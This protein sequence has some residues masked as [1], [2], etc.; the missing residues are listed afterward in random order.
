MPSRP[1]P[2]RSARGR[3]A[4]SG[5]PLASSATITQTF[6]LV[7]MRSSTF[8]SIERA[9]SIGSVA[10]RAGAGGVRDRLDQWTREGGGSL[11]TNTPGLRGA[12][13]SVGAAGQ[14]VPVLPLEALG[15]I[16][17]YRPSRVIGWGIAGTRVC[18]LRLDLEERVTPRI[19]HNTTAIQHAHI[20]FPPFF[21]VLGKTSC[22][23]WRSRYGRA[24]ASRTVSSSS[25]SSASA[26]PSVRSSRSGRSGADASA[27]TRWRRAARVARPT[28]AE[29]R[30]LSRTSQASPSISKARLGSSIG[31]SGSRGPGSAPWRAEGGPGGRRPRSD[32][33]PG[34][35]PG[36]GGRTGCGRTGRGRTEGGGSGGRWGAGGGSAG[37]SGRDGPPAPPPEAC[38]AMGSRCGEPLLSATS[39]CGGGDARCSP[40]GRSNPLRSGAPPR[41]AA[42]GPSDR[43]PQTSWKASFSPS[44]GGPRS[45]GA[46]A[47]N[48]SQTVGAIIIPEVV[49]AEAVEQLQTR[50]ARDGL[51]HACELLE[52]SSLREAAVQGVLQYS[53]SCWST[54]EHAGLRDAL[55]ACR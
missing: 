18:R 48:Q 31:R 34:P 11:K 13:P 39:R 50:W 43:R 29:I 49:W 17:R 35:P 4:A 24:R 45:Q 52:E 26:R 19:S 12:R 32:P 7:L 55:H 37:P 41:P 30:P 10:R 20:P 38:G 36:V 14:A 3:C 40:T 46:G 54:G 15:C 51:S 25:P 22:R 53:S 23:S 8:A 47:G 27:K 44:G 9:R 5:L 1:A 2:G 28:P 21:R 42:L 16:V 33:P 6:V